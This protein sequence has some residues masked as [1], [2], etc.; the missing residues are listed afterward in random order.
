[1]ITIICPDCEYKIEHEPTEPGEVVEC[2]NCGC[3]VLITSLDPLKYEPVDEEKGTYTKVRANC[4][5]PRPPSGIL[6]AK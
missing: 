6:P 1:M 4:S 5:N 2:E 3:E